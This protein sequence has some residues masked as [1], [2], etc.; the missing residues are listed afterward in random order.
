MVAGAVLAMWCF[1]AA[2]IRSTGLSCDQVK[3]G[4][5]VQPLL[6]DAGQVRSAVVADH[7]DGGGVGVGVE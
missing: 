6:G 1:I 7:G 5:F 2:Q 4:V 3:A